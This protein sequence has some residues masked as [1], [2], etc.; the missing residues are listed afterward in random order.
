MHK[1]AIYSVAILSAILLSDN[2]QQARASAAVELHPIQVDLKS[3]RKCEIAKCQG[4]FQDLQ[5]LRS[6]KGNQD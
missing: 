5:Q 6:R 1:C 4:S 3:N 2:G